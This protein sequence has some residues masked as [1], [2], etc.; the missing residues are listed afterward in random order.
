MSTQTSTIHP[1]AVIHPDAVLGDGV[2]VGPYAVIESQVRIGN[3]T[4][5]GS[6]VFVG[7]Y[8]D[9]GS[10]C[11]IHTGAIVGSEPQHKD[12]KGERSYARIGDRVV[13]REYATINRATVLDGVTRIG[14]D[15]LLMAFIHVAHDCILGN[16]VILSNLATLA[17]HIELGDFSVV[18]GQSAIHQWTKIGEGVMVGGTSGVAVHVPPFVTI[19]GYA[20]AKIIRVNRRGLEN[21][22][23]PV[24]IIAQI[25][26]CYRI[27]RRVN[28]KPAAIA[29]IESSVPDSPAR[30]KILRFLKENSPI[31]HFATR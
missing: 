22:N 19:M 21:R 24:E 18:G 16:G 15:C 4:E 7:Q 6:H 14:D 5:I 10:R 25:E 13:I 26:D 9:I 17:G 2:T 11:K 3:G 23:I 30:E 29:E 12:Y 20:P 28:P 1:S 31:A 8:T 27:L